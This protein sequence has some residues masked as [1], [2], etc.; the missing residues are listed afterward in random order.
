MIKDVALC[1]EAFKFTKKTRRILF[2]IQMSRIVFNVRITSL[3]TLHSVFKAI[4]TQTETS[5]SFSNQQQVIT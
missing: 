3:Y 2:Q 5:S 1:E 4:Q